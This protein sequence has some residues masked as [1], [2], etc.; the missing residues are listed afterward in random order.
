MTKTKS[1]SIFIASLSIFIFLIAACPTTGKLSTASSIPVA[2]TSVP[3]S[4]NGDYAYSTAAT[5]KILTIHDGKIFSYSGSSE[6]ETFP[7][8]Y[9]LSGYTV[10]FSESECKATYGSLASIDFTRNSSTGAITYTVSVYGITTTII[11]VKY[12]VS[13]SSSS[14][15]SSSSSSSKSSSTS[16]V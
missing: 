2:I 15:T 5:V 1:I 16:S 4:W 11:Y 13:S 12:T 7:S 8:P 6:T 9:A 10:T 3:S 14:S